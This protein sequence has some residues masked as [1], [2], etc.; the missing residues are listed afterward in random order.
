MNVVARLRTRWVI[1]EWKGNTIASRI[2]RFSME[3]RVTVKDAMPQLSVSY[4]S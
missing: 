4:F 1:F 2:G 3:A